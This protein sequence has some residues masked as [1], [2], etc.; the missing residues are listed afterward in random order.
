MRSF[1][2]G[3]WQQ[4][5]V[6]LAHGCVC[7][8]LFRD[9]RYFVPNPSY[10]AAKKRKHGHQA[11]STPAAA[12]SRPAAVEL[13]VTHPPP[14]APVRAAPTATDAGGND[15][16]ADGAAVVVEIHAGSGV[17]EVPAE[18]ELLKGVH[19]FAEP[20]HLL[21]LMGGSGVSCSANQTAYVSAA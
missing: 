10:S 11:A 8:V 20:G 6:L 17:E 4:Q 5:A 14:A 13:P 12:G 2:P 21:A 15:G 16:A 19:A 18:L 7:A 1:A 9:L 3:C